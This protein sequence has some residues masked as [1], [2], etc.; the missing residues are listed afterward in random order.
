MANFKKHPTGWEFRLKYRD[1]ITQKIK[2]KS[3]R[4]FETKKKRK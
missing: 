2:E 4:G 3:Q 1:P